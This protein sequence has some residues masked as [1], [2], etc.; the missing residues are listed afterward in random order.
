MDTIE[1]TL[2][3]VVVIEPK[4][5]ADPRGHF[6]ELWNQSRYAEAGLAASF[7]QDNQSFSHRG[8]LR[9]LHFQNPNPQ[10]KLVLVLA[11]EAFDVAVDIRLGSPTFGQWVGVTLSGT[12]KRQLYIPPGFAHG[13]AVTGETAIVMYKCTD[14]YDPRAEGNI[15]WNDPAIGIKWPLAA[16][17]LSDKDARAPRLADIPAARL[18]KYIPQSN[19]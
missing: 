8:V 7:V 16:P 9:G 5:Y 18:P 14:Y 1:T 11:G 12:N 6:L 19:D 2:P 17:V 10:G 3:N 13:F 4:V 15:A